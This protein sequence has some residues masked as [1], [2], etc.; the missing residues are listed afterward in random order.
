MREFIKDS[1]KF[2]RFGKWMNVGV[3]FIKMGN[4]EGSLGLEVKEFC[5]E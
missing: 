2:C 1:F 5:F 3:V 4:D